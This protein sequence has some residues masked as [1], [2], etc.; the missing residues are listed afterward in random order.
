MRIIIF[1][2]VTI[3]GFLTTKNEKSSKDLIGFLDEKEKEFIQYHRS[4]ADCIIVGRKTVTIDNPYL[5]NRYGNGNNPDRIIISNSANLNGNEN[6]FNNAG[7]VYIIT[8]K[9]GEK[10]INLKGDNISIISIGEIKVDFTKLKTWLEKEQKYNYVIIEGGASIISQCLIA[11]IVDEIII[12]RLPKIINDNSAP[13]FRLENK[14]H[15]IDV[16]EWDIISVEK[17]N[18][19]IVERYQYKKWVN[20]LG[21]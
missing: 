10:N 13:S 7:Q 9:E 12:L 16:M 2:E 3:D 8:S 21:Y 19:M 5:T 18:N 14:M 6:I 17:Y 15:G 11:K 1:C 4:I 20:K